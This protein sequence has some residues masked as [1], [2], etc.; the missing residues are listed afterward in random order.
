[1]NKI[2]RISVLCLAV[3]IVLSPA[4]VLAHD[5][6]ATEEEAEETV[7]CAIIAAE[8]AT[9]IAVAKASLGFIGIGIGAGLAAIGGGI[10]IGLMAASVA[11][12]SA[13]QPEMYTKLLVILFIAAGFIEGLALFAVVVCL[14]ALMVF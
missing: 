2:A 4:L 9:Q 8:Q 1:V 7:L 5:V 14:L 6:V 3:A 13:R 10:G 11:D 12:A